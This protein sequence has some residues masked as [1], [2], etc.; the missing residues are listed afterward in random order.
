MTDRC[1]QQVVLAVSFSFF[2]AVISGCGGG[3]GGAGGAGTAS[4]PPVTPA[5][6]AV[7]PSAGANGSINPAA[8]QSVGRG[9]T[10]TFTVTA[11]AGYVA[12]VGGTCG[13]TLV[14]TVFTTSVINADCTVIAGFNSV[15][16]IY[17]SV[18]G[19]DANTCVAAQSPATAKQTL[20]A[21]L[22]CLVPGSTLIVRDGIYSG[23]VNALHNL[24]SGTAG[25]AITIKAEND[26]GVIITTGL[27]TG[28]TSAHLIF[29][30]LR[31]HDTFG[32]SILGNHLK[33]FRNEFK[34]GC[35]SGNCANTTV[36]SN[37]VNDTAD[38]LFE[39]NWWH[40]AGGRYNL[41]VYNANRV[42][43]RRAVIRHDGGW[44]DSKGDPEAGINFYNSSNCSAQNVLVIDSDLAYSAWQGAFYAVYNSA[45]P[46]A[47]ANNSWLG[48]I[49]LN[50]PAG[51]AFRLDGNG[52]ITGT[53]VQDM[54]LWD[55]EYAAAL[56]SGSSQINITMNR[57]TA[58]TSRR[59]SPGDGFVQFAS[60]FTG[61]VSNVIVT[62]TLNEQI[63]VPLTFFNSFN[64]GN[65]S[66]G[67]GRVTYSPFANGLQ[68]LTRIET[69]GALK[70]V[71]AGGGQIGAQIVNRIGSAG[72][73]QGETGWNT[74]TGTALWP[75]PNEARIMKEMCT[76]T[77]VTRG[78]CA[79]TSFTRYI[80]N[81]LGNGNPYQ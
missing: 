64:N 28:P 31:F 34:G 7:V 35:P 62:R 56:G 26:G 13:G 17:V 67:G 2:V 11:N 10:A 5:S 66:T 14:G 19:N 71:G 47:N 75:Y 6:F 48:N 72:S 27:N 42:V 29:Q 63:G 3:G 33:F 39:E 81:Y 65:A 12:S 30:G 50:N 46:G 76:D 21:A 57:I 43:V 52:P 54:V 37:D 74:E 51:G 79:D 23:E 16:S 22:V 38:I 61:T 15:G 41:L 20:Q 44:S 77:G 69:G 53:L 24:P 45:S 70:T 73:F 9:T 25:R 49:A 68:Y 32:R 60:A 1:S 18:N 55:S 78:F 59:A 8:P 80:M 58:G 40:G 4:P 36:G